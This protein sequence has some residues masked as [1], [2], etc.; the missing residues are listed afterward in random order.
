MCLFRIPKTDNFTSVSLGVNVA[1]KVV[2]LPENV[3]IQEN[4][5]AP[6][7]EE[8][9]LPVVLFVIGKKK[10]FDGSSQ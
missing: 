5:I 3:L 10:N 2:E 6:P 1:S 8:I 9:G 4:F 7:P